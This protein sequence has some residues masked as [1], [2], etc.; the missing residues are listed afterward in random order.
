M[1]AHLQGAS[2]V[3]GVSGQQILFDN[4]I[5]RQR[6]FAPLVPEHLLETDLGLT[7][8]G[9]TVVLLALAQ[10]DQPADAIHAGGLL[11][12][13]RHVRGQ[14][15]D[16]ADFPA[17]G[18][19]A[20]VA[21]GGVAVFGEIIAIQVHD[22][23]AHAGDQRQLVGQLSAVFGEQRHL[24]RRAGELVAVRRSTLEL[25]T[26]RVVQID[27][28]AVGGDIVIRRIAVQAEVDAVVVHAHQGFAVEAEQVVIEG[29]GLT[30][31]KLFLIVLDAEKTATQQA[32][33]GL[34][35]RMVFGVLPA[36]LGFQVIQFVAG[37][38]GV[39]DLP[40]GVQA[41]PLIVVVQFGVAHVV[42]FVA[43]T[44]VVTAVDQRHAKVVLR[45]LVA[46][47]VAQREGQVICGLPAQGG[48]DEGV[49]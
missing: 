19:Q 45:L 32:L 29:E 25:A 28:L 9:Q 5:R 23:A 2:D 20:T 39:A 47:V 22:V 33:A 43:Q 42:V 30:V 7:R 49:F 35:P 3:R 10:A 16:Q 34:V 8:T 44:L 11:G 38:Q 36:P 40:F 1:L 14:F 46:V 17:V 4:V 13:E 18:G 21:A 6:P 15:I 27:R 26:V 12:V 37:A 24:L 48:A 41:R 31:T